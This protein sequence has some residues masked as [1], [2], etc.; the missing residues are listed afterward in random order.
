MEVTRAVAEGCSDFEL[1][2]Y[3][4]TSIEEEFFVLTCGWHIDKGGDVVA[5]VEGTEESVEGAPESTFPACSC[6]GFAVAIDGYAVSHQGVC[7]GELTTL[8]ISV[9][10]AASVLFAFR[11]IRLIETDLC[12]GSEPLQR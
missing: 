4:E 3:G 1:V 11:D 5:R 12:P 8:F 7:F 6:E 10:Q 9:Q 2:S